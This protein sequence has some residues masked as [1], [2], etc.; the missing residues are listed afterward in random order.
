MDFQYVGGGVGVRDLAYLMGALSSPLL[1]QRGEELLGVYFARL[2]ACIEDPHIG[3]AVEAEWRS[4][5][6]V[7]WADFERFMTGWGGGQGTR[8]RPFSAARVQAGLDQVRAR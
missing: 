5:F 3:S 2:L 8:R 4:L 7:A 1:E 6:D